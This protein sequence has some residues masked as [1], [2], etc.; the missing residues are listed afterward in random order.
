VEA[1]GFAPFDAVVARAFGSL[2]E[3]LALGAPLLRPGGELWAMKG[4]RWEAEARQI[5]PAVRAAFE[6][7]P[8]VYPYRLE[9][10]GAGVVLVYRRRPERP[11][12][13]A[14]TAAP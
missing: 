14:D 5:P 12:A 1:P 8:S 9:D 2:A 7:R 13:S 10:G 3:L 11:A 6:A 4:R